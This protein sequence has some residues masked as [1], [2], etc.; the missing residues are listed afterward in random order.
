MENYDQPAG[1]KQIVT[2]WLQNVAVFV[3]FA[4]WH[5][6]WVWSRGCNLTALSYAWRLIGDRR[7]LKAEVVKILW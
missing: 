1:I 4:R 2:V 6:I 3:Q 7:K 5:F